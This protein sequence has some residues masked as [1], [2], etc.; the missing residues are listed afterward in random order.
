M[1]AC[2]LCLAS[3]R[4]T[5]TGKPLKTLTAIRSLH[6]QHIVQWYR[7]TEKDLQISLLGLRGKRVN[8]CKPWDQTCQISQSLNTCHSVLKS[9]SSIKPVLIWLTELGNLDVAIETSLM[10]TVIRCLTTTQWCIPSEQRFDL[11][12]LVSGVLFQF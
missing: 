9:Y 1:L 2:L 3:F 11:A 12:V 10:E 8:A 4:C 7:I 6:L 5:I